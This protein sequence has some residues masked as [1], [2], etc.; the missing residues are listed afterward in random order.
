M[1]L[2]RHSVRTRLLPAQQRHYSHRLLRPVPQIEL[3]PNMATNQS[4]AP[5]DQTTIIKDQFLNQPIEAHPERWDN[6]WKQGI[7]GW[8]RQG[9]SLALKDT[10]LQRPECFGSPWKDPEHKRR[11]RAFVPGCGRGYDVLLLASLGYDAYGLDVS[12]T[13]V[14]AAQKYAQELGDSPSYA[15]NG[16][17]VGRGQS[18]FLLNDFYKDDFLLETQG[19]DFDLIFDYT[20]LCA[21][22]PD[23][24]P[25]WA[26][27]MRELL[28][29]DGRLVCL[30]WPMHKPPKNGGPPHGLS[31]I[32]YMELFKTP[33]VDPEY[34][35]EGHAVETKRERAKGALVREAHFQPHR[36]HDAGKGKDF[37]S[38]WKHT[39]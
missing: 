1:K 39:R 27:R 37:V 11:K 14:A 16:P 22:P 5:T 26:T 12:P 3:A 2:C 32:L 25:K 8:D 9:P 35:G 31:S 23:M 10:I 4:Q 7:T 15:V 28:G 36:T 18:K 19:G 24:R 34:D 30:Q 29:Q 17:A 38:V 13:A 21:M 20:F 33:G 6:L